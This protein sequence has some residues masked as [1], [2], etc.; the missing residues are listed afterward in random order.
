MHVAGG[1]EDWIA[2]SGDGPWGGDPDGL[3]LWSND[4]IGK[5]MEWKSVGNNL[6]YPVGEWQEFTL[7]VDKGAATLYKDG[8]KIAEGTVSATALT[9]ENA[10]L[11]IGVNA[12]DDVPD[13]LVDTVE[14]TNKLVVPANPVTA[15]KN[16]LQAAVDAAE[17]AG[18]VEA[19]YTKDSWA[20]YAKALNDAKAVLEDTD[21]DQAAVDAAKAALENA[22]AGLVK[23]GEEPPVPEKKLLADFNFD[24]APAEGE[25]F[26]GGNALATGSYELVDHDGG[27]ALKLNGKDQ[28]LSVTD[29]DGK[30]LLTGVD[31]LT[32]S[33]QTRP[34]SSATN[35][36]FFAA[37]NDET[38][39]YKSEHYIGVFDNGGKVG[40]ERYN[41]NNQERPLVPSYQANE[42]NWY[43]V[44]AVFTKTETI[45]YVN[46]V[47]R[48]REESKV[49]IAAL[50]GNESI[51]QIGHSTWRPD[52]KPNGEFYTGL[53]DNYK[54]YNYALSAEEIAELA[55]GHV[56][57]TDL[58]AAIKTEVNAE[59]TY[60]PDSWKVYADA[61][62]AAKDVYA[63][64]NAT[65][66]AINEAA[67]A[68]N[69]AIKALKDRADKAALAAAIAKAEAIPE[70]DAAKYTKDSWEAM[71]KALADAKT[72][73]EDANATQ[74]KVNSAAKKLENAI[75]GLEE[76]VNSDKTKLQEAVDNKEPD[77][78]ADEYTE[79][80][81]AAYQDALKE[82][83]KVL[84][85]D[86][87]DQAAV[88]AAEKALADAKAALK[89]KKLPYDDVEEGTWYYD[90][91]AY[92]YYA[93]TMTGLKPD[94]F[95]PAD[96]LVRAQFAAVLH[97]MNDEVEVEYTD[98]F[99]DVTEPDWFKNAVLWAA[100]NEIVTG[101][102]GTDL[103]GPNDVVTREQM[104]T[105]M[106]RYAKNFKEYE[107]SADGD[108]S[109]FPDAESI[110]P[111]AQ[112]A[113]KW[114]VKEEII[115]GKTID[116]VLLLDPQGSANRAECA[117][118]IQRFLE[119][120]GK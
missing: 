41:S 49:D 48:A 112:E 16:A 85:D 79:E 23:E 104:A 107:V 73:N 38:Q 50:L 20:D 2:L 114:A 68:L 78:K 99:S 89:T 55:S 58:D 8:V 27:K 108:C 52:D 105:M 47:E 76:P 40:A 111:F 109:K 31:E 30:S 11:C 88:D 81:W 118:I 33:Y 13:M 57:K 74:T 91:I 101:Y 87:A 3:K 36:G 19:E 32:V 110:Q 7:C 69:N 62:K 65:Q 66:D 67:L 10:T 17:E 86:K 117:T 115:T 53:I 12:W 60:T 72:V 34:G 120:Y 94:H 113:M 75:A 39:T 46:G 95:G 106:Y 54:I 25:A 43:Y 42:D 103:F 77:D 116:G 18:Y 26:D 83:E 96:T 64:E 15:D 45:I 44:T 82:A 70:E 14:I 92:N 21:A 119:K 80:S 22:I 56:D 29:K 100:E 63:D 93:G 5:T 28:F 102:T 61:L 84:A 6:A 9:R 35:W 98:K 4:N 51:C 24:A 37:P 1:D 90:A 59:D 97:K 71:K